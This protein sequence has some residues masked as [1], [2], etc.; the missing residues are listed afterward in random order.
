MAETR[1]AWRVIV[2]APERSI[3]ALTPPAVA[4]PDFGVLDCRLRQP[5]AISYGVILTGAVFQAEGRISRGTGRRFSG[6]PGDSRAPLRIQT[7]H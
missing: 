4:S 6:G 7:H 2:T 1:Y 5:P 3:I